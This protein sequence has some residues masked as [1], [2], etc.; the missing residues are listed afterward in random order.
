MV[1]LEMWIFVC[2][3]SVYAE[4][5]NELYHVYIHTVTDIWLYVGVIMRNTHA[6]VDAVH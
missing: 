2:E 4:G 6:D 3:F 1:M 5:M